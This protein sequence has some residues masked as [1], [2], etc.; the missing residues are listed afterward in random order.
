[1][2]PHPTAALSL[3]LKV[4]TGVLAVN[5]VT[6]LAAGAASKL[7]LHGFFFVFVVASALFLRAGRARL[8]G[9]VLASG[10][11][12][13]ATIS[14]FVFGGVRSPGLY[15]YLPVVLTAGLFWSNR[16]A[17]GLAMASVVAVALA[18]Q[19]QAAGILHEPAAPML[20]RPHAHGLRRSR[21]HDGGL[22]RCRAQKRR[23]DPRRARALGGA[24][25]RARSRGARRHSF[26]RRSRCRR[27]RE[28]FGDRADRLSC[29]GVD[30][31]LVHGTAPPR[32]GS[33]RRRASRVRRDAGRRQASS[34]EIELIKRDG[35][36]IVVEGHARRVI[37]EGG[38]VRVP[39]DAPRRHR[40]AAARMGARDARTS[41]R[42]RGTARFDRASRWRR[43]ARLQQHPHP[44]HEQRVPSGEAARPGFPGAAIPPR[45][46][47]TPRRAPLRSCVSC[48][49]PDAVGGPF[50]PSR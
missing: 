15:V 18:A 32:P 40:A 19:L 13:G 48:S 39:G 23:G 49:R 4:S 8:A 12:A 17:V 25:R 14:V 7:L 1:M 34:G 9:A 50:R 46:S 6:L 24:V 26:G 11:W 10:F 22:A 42:E 44:D 33:A 43:R 21:A 28:S 27:R 5:A 45:R 38:E 20:A 36:C 31:R 16:A 35:T 37:R 47:R 41:S 2:A 29:V 30:G 3:V